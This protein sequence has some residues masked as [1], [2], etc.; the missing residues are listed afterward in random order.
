MDLPDVGS[1][2]S[3]HSANPLSCAAALA[4]IKEIISRKLIKESARKGKILHNGLNALKNKYP[5]H[6]SYILGKGF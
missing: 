3:T 4:N 5:E 2:S 6:I 1:M